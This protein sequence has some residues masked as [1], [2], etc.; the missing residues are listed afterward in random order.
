MLACADESLQ[1]ASG[2]ALA[3]MR[4]ASRRILS[5]AAA[6]S[7]GANDY[8]S[9]LRRYVSR[10]RCVSKVS[11]CVH[12]V[13][14]SQAP[15]LHQGCVLCGCVSS[16]SHTSPSPHPRILAAS[17]PCARFLPVLMS[18]MMCTCMCVGCARRAPARAPRSSPPNHLPCAAPGNGAQALEEQGARAVAALAI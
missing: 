3:S 5:V 14:V 17:C 10:H 9:D 2:A 8:G 13:T 4:C 16:P 7:Y 12:G 6:S 15:V 18:Y 1:T 11:T